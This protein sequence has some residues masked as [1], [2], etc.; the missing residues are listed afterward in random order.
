MMNRKLFLKFGGMNENIYLGEDKEFIQ[1]F[2]KQNSSIKVFYNPKLFVYHKE[3][4]LIKF[5]IQR[6]VFGAD[7][8]NITNFNYKI[9]I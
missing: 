4:N 1:R 2:K 6:M 9:N 8:Y 7:L 5:L 3:R